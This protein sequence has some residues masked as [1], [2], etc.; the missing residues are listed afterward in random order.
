MNR[1]TLL[2]LTGGSLLFWAVMMV[3]IAHVIH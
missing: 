3:T 1:Y 2:S